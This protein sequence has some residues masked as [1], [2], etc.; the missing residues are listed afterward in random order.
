MSEQEKRYENF[1]KDKEN[2]LIT[3][4]RGGGYGVMNMETLKGYHVM[5]TNGIVTCDCPDYKYRGSKKGFHCKHMIAV[6]ENWKKQQEEERAERVAK[7]IA[8][9]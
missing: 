7:A 9:W 1:K 4:L 3:K 5:K 2:F 6:W 8:R